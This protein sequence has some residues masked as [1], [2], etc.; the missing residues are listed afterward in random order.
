MSAHAGMIRTLPVGVFRALDPRRLALGILAADSGRF[1]APSASKAGGGGATAVEAL[2]AT[3]GEAVERYCMMVHDRTR[4]VR[5]SYRELAEHAVHP[6]LLRLHAR[7][8]ADAAPHRLTYFDADTCCDWIWCWSLT[9]ERARLVPADLVY[10][11]YRADASRPSIA[12]NASSGLAAG[13]TLEEAILSGL[14]EVIERDAATI[15]WLHRR[16]QRRIAIDDPALRAQ[17][18]SDF[19][20]D[21]PEV[22]L[23]FFDLTLDIPVPTV[24]SVMRRPTELGSTLVIAAATR[25]EPRRAVAK[26]LDEMGQSIPYFRYLAR[27]LGG[28]QPRA[29]FSDVTAF[30]FH[31]MLYLKRPELAAPALAF[32]AEIEDEVPLGALADLSTGTV[33]GDVE[34]CLGAL[35]AA[36]WEAIVCDITAPDVAQAGFHVVRVLVPGLVPLHGDHNFPYL[37]VERLHE[38]PQRLGW[39]QTAGLNPWPH[40]YP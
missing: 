19:H 8:Q 22:E 29:D 31:C 32:C 40:P 26:C 14:Y 4:I 11:G 36:G 23:A 27:R 2:A 13:V 37:G 17:V 5:G 25:L 10:V 12:V 24:F 3:L 7:G 6:D 21:L 39:G 28:W 15:S 20:T 38:V 34:R 35:S 30:D 16:V 9:H 33:R 18:A 1:S